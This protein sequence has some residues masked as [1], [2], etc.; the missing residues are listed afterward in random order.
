MPVEDVFSISGRGTV[1]T[2]R[3]ERGI[4]KVNDE[5]EIVGSK[6][7]RRRSCTGVE[8]FRK[9]LDQGRRATTSACCCAARSARKWS[10]AG[11]G[12]AGLDH[13]AH[14]VRGRG[15]RA[16]EG[17]GRPSHAVLQGLSPQFYFRTTDVTGGGAAGGREM[18]MPGDNIKMTSS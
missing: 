18:V 10:A 8:M 15:V 13:A 5:V 1:V 14:E 7:R 3:I 11:A 9:L 6:R 4:V 2:G 12:E 16:D 17:R